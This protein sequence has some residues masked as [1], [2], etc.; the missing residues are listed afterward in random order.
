MSTAWKIIISVVITLVVATGGTYYYMNQKLENEKSDLQNQITAL[1]EQIE[2]LRLEAANTT[3]AVD[4]SEDEI[5]GTNNSSNASWKDYTNSKY[6]FSLT[7]N[8]LWKNYEIIEK[9]PDDSTA[10]AYLY[11]CVPTTSSSWSDQKSGMF[12]PFTITVVNKSGK[13]AFEQA[14]DPMVPTYINS[15]SSYSFY[16]STAQDRPSD[17]AAVMNDI[18]TVIGTFKAN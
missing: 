3:S 8:D 11:V 16:Y 7:L 13:T 15:N 9:S 2:Q 5:S 4:T 10:T 18:S 12:C 17:G 1:N 14:N 6:D